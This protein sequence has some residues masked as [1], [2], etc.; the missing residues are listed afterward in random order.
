MKK[1][2]IIS[3]ALIC[4]ITVVL[5]FTACNKGGSNP[6]TETWDKQPVLPAV[7]YSYSE[8]HGIDDHQATLGRVLFYDQNLS[9]N[10]AVSCGS[11]HKQQFAFAD[12]VQFNKGFN[13]VALN[14]NSPS[15]QGIRNRF[16]RQLFRDQSQLPF[17]SAPPTLLFWDGRQTSITDMMLNPVTN[18]NEMNMPDFATLE[19]KLARVSYYP[20]L[21]EKAYGSP[22]ITGPKISTALEAFIACLNTDN[23]NK[24]MDQ[25]FDGP[26]FIGGGFLAP[27]GTLTA[28]EEQGRQLFH[29]KYNCATCHDPT[30]GGG[31][32]GGGGG[33][34]TM[35]NIGL[36]P[37]G[38]GDQGQGAVTRK[39]AHM[40]VFKVPT[41]KNIAVTAPY[42]HDGRYK[43]L[44]EVIDHYSHKVA[45]HRNLSPVLKNMDGSPKIMD[46][47]PAE[48]KAL[49]AFLMTLKDEDFLTSP[50]YADPFN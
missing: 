15:I 13:G 14:R 9:V 42:M 5:V 12:N 10:N 41:L 28:L 2:L 4:S 49:I 38:T 7:T 48:K 29:T 6:V 37:D 33:F 24:T 17:F 23:P 45:P 25:R 22:E 39:Q 21:F 16:N 40:G 31:Y 36:D 11:C 30:H 20:A 27:T 8:K 50:M 47:K 18:H 46:I 44:G 26:F 43:N 19:K 34:T 1:R 35:F 3:S 32:D